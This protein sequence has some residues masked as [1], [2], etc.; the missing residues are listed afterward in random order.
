MVAIQTLILEDQID[1][2][3]AV[4]RT[5]LWWCWCQPLLG[6]AIHPLSRLNFVVRGP[7]PHGSS[8]ESC[9]GVHGPHGGSRN[10][11]AASS[12]LAAG[13]YR[14]DAASSLCRSRSSARA[15]AIVAQARA[16]SRETRGHPPLG[17]K[18]RA[19][20]G[21]CGFRF[22]VGHTLWNNRGDMGTLYDAQGKVISIHENGD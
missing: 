7:R 14:W 1:Q 10:R 5:A 17:R 9:D 2:D 4:G 22:G 11:R 13:F 18:G 6:P 12:E 8:S 19:D 16:P 21:H 20:L 15:A 3:E